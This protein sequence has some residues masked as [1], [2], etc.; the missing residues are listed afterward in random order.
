MRHLPRI[1]LNAATAASLVLCVATLVVWA[2]DTQF[3]VGYEHHGQ[4]A[5]T[6]T[7]H[8][9]GTG[10]FGGT[11]GADALRVRRGTSGRTKDA[12]TSSP[13]SN[14]FRPASGGLGPSRTTGRDPGRRS[15]GTRW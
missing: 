12:S 7:Q 1:L 13:S 2:A 8:F 9:E 14:C 15:E 4:F 3:G 10:L 11:A 6:E 5:R